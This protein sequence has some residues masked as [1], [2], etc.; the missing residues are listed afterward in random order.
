M[1]E[2]AECIVGGDDQALGL[3]NG[4]DAGLHIDLGLIQLLGIVRAVL[5]VGITIRLVGIAEGID[6]VLHIDLGVGDRLESMRVEGTVIVVMLSACLRMAFF[7]FL[8]LEGLD[9]L[10]QLD[11]GRL[12]AARL[13]QPRQET[14][15]SQTIDQN[16]IRLCQRRRIRWLGLIDMAVA[17]RAD[18]IGQR[19]LVAADV[20]GEILDDGKAGNNLQVSRKSGG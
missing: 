11:N 8:R 19:N 20:L 9:T 7:L 10:G 12:G 14:F 6:D 3:R 16:H 15:K 18:Q 17:V 1:L 13:D 4:G 2:I 5:L